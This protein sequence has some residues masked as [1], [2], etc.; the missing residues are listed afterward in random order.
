M[1]DIRHARLDPCCFSSVCSTFYHLYSMNHKFSKHSM[2]SFY[3]RMGQSPSVCSHLAPNRP[4]KS[5]EKETTFIDK[6]L[7]EIRLM[8]IYCT[9][10]LSMRCTFTHL[11][12]IRCI[13]IMLADLFILLELRIKQ[14]YSFFHNS[15]I[16]LIKLNNPRISMNHML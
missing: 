2:C 5:I 13:Q 12:F 3:A 9:V 16:I 14:S 4:N 8:R 10:A 15:F 6:L 7:S 11:F 1:R